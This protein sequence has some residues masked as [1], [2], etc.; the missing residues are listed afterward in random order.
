MIVVRFIKMLTH[1]AAVDRL[2]RLPSGYKVDFDPDGLTWDEL[3]VLGAMGAK[4]KLGVKRLMD[5]YD[6]E[7]VPELL[8]VL[9]RKKI[10]YKH[11]FMN[12]L[13]RL[14]GSSETPPRRRYPDSGQFVSRSVDSVR[15][16]SRRI[17]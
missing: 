5:E 16:F 7:T 4:D 2:P 9:P 13:R 6:V 15:G 3:Q 14:E 10:D 11:R 17:D 8:A 1:I 12:W